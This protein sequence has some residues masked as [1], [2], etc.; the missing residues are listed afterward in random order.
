MTKR[1]RWTLL[2]VVFLYTFNCIA[3]VDAYD[4]RATILNAKKGWNTIAL[5]LDIYSKSK[6]ELSDIRIYK[7]DKG[8]NKSIEQPYILDIQEAKNNSIEAELKIIN[9]TKTEGNYSRF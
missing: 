4:Y 3:Q 6:N 5:P 9:K 2:F 8:S 7:V 1:L